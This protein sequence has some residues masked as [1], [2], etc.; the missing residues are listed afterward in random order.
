MCNVK[1]RPSLSNITVRNNVRGVRGGEGEGIREVAKRA[2]VAWSLY[3]VFLLDARPLPTGDDHGPGWRHRSKGRRDCRR[4]RR[5]AR[6]LV[7]SRRTTPKSPYWSAAHTRTC[8]HTRGA[9]RTPLYIRPNA[10]T[11]ASHVAYVYFELHTVR[12][13]TP[14]RT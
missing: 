9:H 4:R 6:P 13:R 3:S 8:T 14:R 11:Y 2:S 5:R 1:K 10:K 12:T 7:D